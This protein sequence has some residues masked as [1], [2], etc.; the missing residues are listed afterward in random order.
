M[1]SRSAHGENGGPVRH[2]MGTVRCKIVN[3]GQ[4]PGA[5]YCCERSGGGCIG[6]PCGSDLH[7]LCVYGYPVD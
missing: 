1:T 5:V 2:G 4:M 7:F 3:A 6:S